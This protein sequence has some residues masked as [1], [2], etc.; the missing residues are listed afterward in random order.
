MSLW[1]CSQ[2][3]LRPPALLPPSYVSMCILS[4][5]FPLTNS[6]FALL[7]LITRYHSR[8]LILSLWS[9]H[10]MLWDTLQQ[11]VIDVSTVG[12]VAVIIVVIVG[13]V[14]ASPPAATAAAA[15]WK[16]WQ[17]IKLSTSH[18][19]SPFLVLFSSPFA[20]LLL[21]YHHH[22]VLSLQIR[23]LQLTCQDRDGG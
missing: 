22:H 11:I 2:I 1:R 19:M 5:P 18:R 3:N 17:S 23:S 13:T 16:V 21:R 6:L 7:S 4:H 9:S 10:E 12:V 15:A 20:V 14:F 8:A